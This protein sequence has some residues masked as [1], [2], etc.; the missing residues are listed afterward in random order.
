MSDYYF[1]PKRM[2]K[3][4]HFFAKFYF[5]HFV[6]RQYREKKTKIHEVVSD[7]AK[8][9]IENQSDGQCK[10]LITVYTDNEH[11]RTQTQRRCE[12][13]TNKS[14][15]NFSTDNWQTMILLSQNEWF[16]QRQTQMQ[17]QHLRFI[18]TKA[19][20]SIGNEN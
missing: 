19:V 13:T 3:L 14:N 16:A 4:I 12:T 17:M 6:P 11:A 5:S 10:L 1:A 20:I 9:K 15:R 7:R 18:E 2:S 8:L